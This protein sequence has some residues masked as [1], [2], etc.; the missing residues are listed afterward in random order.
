MLG[1]RSLQTGRRV[2]MKMAP[3]QLG[4]VHSGQDCGLAGGALGQAFN[5]QARIGD[6]KS[7]VKRQPNLFTLED[8]KELRVQSVKRVVIPSC[9]NADTIDED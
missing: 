2:A 1:E 7:P 6:C 4:C 8:R 3:Y 9:P 5:P